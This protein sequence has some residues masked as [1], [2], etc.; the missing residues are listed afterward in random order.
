M[1]IACDNIQKPGKLTKGIFF[2]VVAVSLLPACLFAFRRPAYNWDMLPYMAIV[3]KM[4]KPWLNMEGIHTLTYQMASQ[5]V[6]ETDYRLL[7]EGNYRKKMAANAAAF[8]EQLP[9]YSVKPLYVGMIYLLYKT[10]FSLVSSTML[11]SIIAY[12]FL[13][14]LLFYWMGRYLRPLFAL[15]GSVLVM[16]TPFMIRIAGLSSPDALSSFLLFAAF[17]F[18]IEKPSLILLFI[19]FLLAIGAR[20][21]HIIT[22]LIILSF[23]FFYRKWEKRMTLLQYATMVGAVVVCYFVI[24]WFTV[25]PWGWNIAFYPAF[26]HN[27]NLTY[28]HNRAFSLRKYAALAY[29]RAITGV[30]YYQFT[31]FAF[32]ALLPAIPV[33]KRKGK[34][35]LEH[36]F[37]L[38]LI[39]I[40]LFRFALYP[41]LADRFYAS[42]YLC[43]LLLLVRQSAKKEVPADRLSR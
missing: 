5:K 17:Y 3:L 39:F 25:R 42:F 28:Q 33:F 16:Y 15:L 40:I 18:I 21:D 36:W 31:L 41:A 14:L 6:P 10:G 13:G 7:K 22:C 12:F 4:D 11:P 1:H 26:A 20:L 9:F 30:V 2:V 8:G 32:L 43:I 38:L 19:F 35:G 29:S 27:L 37:A 34:P 24:T 23:L